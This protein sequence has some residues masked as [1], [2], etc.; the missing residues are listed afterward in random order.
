VIDRDI[1]TRFRISSEPNL[2]VTGLAPDG[3]I[4]D[5]LITIQPGAPMVIPVLDRSALALLML[6]I[7]G[8]GMWFSRGAGLTRR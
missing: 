8:L 1:G 2:G 6:L 5:F 7:I 4:E 3:E